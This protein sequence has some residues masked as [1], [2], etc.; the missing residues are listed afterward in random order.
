VTI[1]C[2]SEIKSIAE[3]LGG[4]LIWWR[5]G[6]GFLEEK[7]LEEKALFAGEQTSHFYFNEFYPFSDGTLSTLYLAKILM[8]KRKK[9]SKFVDELKLHPTGKI[10]ID[11]A[12]DETKNKVMEE[13][14]KEFPES[15]ELTDGLKIQLNKIEWV[16]IRPGH[17]MPAINLCAEGKNKKRLKQILQKYSK[18]INKKIRVVK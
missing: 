1:D 4:E 14:K 10:Y 9:L 11:T 5:I 2:A 16:L 7:V 18:A 8:K 12:S 3:K 17:T 13:M 15:F 6:H